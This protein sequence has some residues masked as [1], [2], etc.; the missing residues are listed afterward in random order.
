MI[1]Y[2]GLFFFMYEYMPAGRNAAYGVAQSRQQYVADLSLGNRLPPMRQPAALASLVDA[3]RVAERDEAQGGSAACGSN[4]RATP[5]RS[6]LCARRSRAVQTSNP[7]RSVP[8]V[9][10]AQLK[11]MPTSAAR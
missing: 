11:H 2:C 4:I 7:L 6:S 10:P 1:T 8:A 5:P 9:R 3:L